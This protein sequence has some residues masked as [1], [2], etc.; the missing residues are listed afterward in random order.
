MASQL[1]PV[2][3]SRGKVAMTLLLQPANII[4]SPPRVFTQKRSEQGLVR[5]AVDLLI[6]RYSGHQNS[7]GSQT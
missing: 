7:I 4:R 3:Q 1:E 6:E 5:E 2:E